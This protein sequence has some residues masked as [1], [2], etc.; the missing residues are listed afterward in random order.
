MPGAALGP[1]L[2]LRVRCLARRQ[3]RPHTDRRRPIVFPTC[4]RWTE[5]YRG[6]NYSA[7]TTVVGTGPDQS[8][9]SGHPETSFYM[10]TFSM[11]WDR[12][13]LLGTKAKQKQGPFCRATVRL[14]RPTGRGWPKP[15]AVPCA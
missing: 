11:A 15:G 6:D 4:L 8:T 3:M 12:E 5:G 1:K 10:N 13:V 7:W 2:P 9:A 14:P